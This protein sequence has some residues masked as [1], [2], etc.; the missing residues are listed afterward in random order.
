MSVGHSGSIMSNPKAGASSRSPCKGF[1]TKLTKQ[2]L[3]RG[4]L[5]GIVDLQGVINRPETTI[6]PNPSS[7][8]R[9]PSP[10]IG[11]RVEPLAVSLNPKEKS[12]WLTR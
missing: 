5:R 7:G 10:E 12:Q 3:K 11:F 6:T 2:R 9:S 8:Q 1:S 4:V